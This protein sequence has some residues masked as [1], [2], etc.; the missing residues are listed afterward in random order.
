MP[1][2]VAVD[3]VG[4][5]ASSSASS[6][7]SHRHHRQHPPCGS[8]LQAILLCS[9]I[10]VCSSIFG[11]MATNQAQRCAWIGTVPVG[12]TEAECIL[13]VQ[14]CCGIAPLRMLLRDSSGQHPNR[15]A[16]AHFSTER[17]AQTF[18]VIRSM[19][20]STGDRSLVRL[21]MCPGVDYESP[22]CTVSTGVG[23]GGWGG[24]GVV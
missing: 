2:D 8:F 16:V 22:Y 23:D 14:S 5:S 4:P 9:S 17:E 15:F 11:G 24:A 21:L 18:K 12:L 10:V 7:T 20:W 6:S 13:E 1:T 19:T 3:A